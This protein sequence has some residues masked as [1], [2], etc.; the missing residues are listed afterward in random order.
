M[1]LLNRPAAA[2]SVAI[3]SVLLSGCGAGA[4]P[5]STKVSGNV[6]WQGAPL[7]SG[8]ITFRGT[9]AEG[10]AGAPIVKG[11]YSTECLPGSKRVEITANRTSSDKKDNLGMP[12]VEQ[13]VPENYNTKSELTKEVKAGATNVFDFD[14]K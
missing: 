11:Q 5:G 7:E 8:V 1:I 9:G 10:S 3:L 14:L 6:T 13:Y 4:P 12:L 2:V